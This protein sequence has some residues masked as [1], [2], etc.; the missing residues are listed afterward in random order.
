MVILHPRTVYNSRQGGSRRTQ[1][2]GN[3][4]VM[5]DTPT[6]YIVTIIGTRGD[7]RSVKLEPS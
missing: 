6:G 1:R 7:A 4:I 5:P 3:N 2:L